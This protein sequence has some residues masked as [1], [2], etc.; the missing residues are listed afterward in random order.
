DVNH[1]IL[2][3]PWHGQRPS[4][5]IEYE[6]GNQLITPNCEAAICELRDAAE[7]RILW[8][9]SISIGKSNDAVQERNS[10]VVIKGEIYKSARKVVVWLGESDS[11]AEAAIS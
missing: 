9:D 7:T 3:S 11:R 1:T 2:S 4:C 5:E 10:Q 8:I 6:C